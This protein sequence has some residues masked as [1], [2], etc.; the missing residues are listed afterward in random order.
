MKKVKIEYTFFNEEEMEDWEDTMR[1]ME[2]RDWRFHKDVFD[3]FI[4]EKSFTHINVIWR[5]IDE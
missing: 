5:E 4:P 3:N 2:K 1:K